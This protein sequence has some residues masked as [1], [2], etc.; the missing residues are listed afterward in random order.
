M[1]FSQW[2]S[3]FNDSILTIVVFQLISYRIEIKFVV[4]VKIYNAKS[5]DEI[6]V[7]RTNRM[8]VRKFIPTLSDHR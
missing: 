1:I 8:L 5:R 3:N 4:I 6:E 7:L 2:F